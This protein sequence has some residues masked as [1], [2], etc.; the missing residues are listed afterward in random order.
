M[1]DPIYI[2]QRGDL[3]ITNDEALPT[4]DVL[5]VA[6]NLNGYEGSLMLASVAF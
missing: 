5:K 2:D 3:W 1:P 6:P 4:E